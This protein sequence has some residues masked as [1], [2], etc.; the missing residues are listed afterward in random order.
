MRDQFL[1]MQKTAGWRCGH[2]PL[3]GPVI[4]DRLTR[5]GRQGEPSQAD[6]ERA[7]DVHALTKCVRV[8]VLQIKL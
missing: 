5:C 1:A 6:E 3:F 7:A 4:I 2:S 8:S